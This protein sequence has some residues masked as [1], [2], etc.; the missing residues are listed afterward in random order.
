MSVLFN[1]VTFSYNKNQKVLEDISLKINQGESVGLIGANGA[2]KSTL[3][4]LM[5]GLVDGY[6]GEIVVCDK[7]VK[8]ENYEAIRKNTGFVFQDSDSQ[9]FMSTVYEDVAFGP[10]NYGLD[11]EQV[12]KNVME[13]LSMVGIEDLKDRQIYK[14]SG[15]QKKLAS[16]AT[17]L[18]MKPS[19]ILFD[20]PS[21]M[22]D[23]RNRRNLI[24]IFNGLEATKIVASHDLDFILDT[25]ERTILIGDGT[26]KFDGATSEIM[27][28]Q[29]L[30]EE[31][32][33][34]LPLSYARR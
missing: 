10:R 15:G 20:E 3:L 22:L 33:L 26:I 9:L 32:G 4:R 34:E 13:A 6:K 18:S 30:L 28:N 23:P 1:N 12:H 2:G 17:I 7:E 29:R 25:C 8:K 19:M 21:I 14:M 27:T 31:N 11:K 24:N 5:V 16:I